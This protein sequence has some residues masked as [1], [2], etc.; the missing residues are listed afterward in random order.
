MKRENIMTNVNTKQQEDPTVAVCPVCGRESHAGDLF[1][2]D[3]VD[4]IGCPD[5]VLVGSVVAVP[6]DPD[7]PLQDL[8]KHCAR[9]AAWLDAHDCPICGRNAEL[10]V[11]VTDGAW[12]CV[13]GCRDQAEAEGFDS[14]LDAVDAWL[15]D[16]DK[17]VQAEVALKAKLGARTRILDS[18]EREIGERR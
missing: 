10:S 13:C 9:W 5:H 17:R 6:G 18:L 1:A 11:R 15:D 14:P 12:V 16:R 2:L 4:H 3:G 7:R 8:R